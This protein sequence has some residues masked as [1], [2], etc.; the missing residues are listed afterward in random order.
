M[1][2]PL[3]TLL[4]L[5]YV[6]CFAMLVMVIS[7]GKLSLTDKISLQVFTLDDFGSNRGQTAPTTDLA[8]LD[9]LEEEI[10]QTTPPTPLPQTAPSTPDTLALT[11]E[12]QTELSETLREARQPIDYPDASASAL[13]HF[14]DA[15][16][17]LSQRPSSVRIVHYGDSQ[18]EGD[19]ISGYL[20]E[21]LQ[22][23]FG[24]CGVGMVPLWTRD[25]LRST[26]KT[27]PSDTWKKFAYVDA[28]HKPSTHQLGMLAAYYK[29]TPDRDSA[30][31]SKARYGSVV[32]TG[33]SE[34]DKNPPAHHQTERLRLLFRNPHGELQAEIALNNKIIATQTQ[35]IGKGLQ[36]I[37]HRLPE[38]SPYRNIKLRLA[39]S[40]SP[41]L[42]GF[43]MDCQTGISLDN[44][45]I[46]GSSGV[47]FTKIDKER[48]R[49]QF[50]A[51]DVRLLILEFGVNVVPGQAESYA[52]YE[53]LYYKQLKFF[54]SLYPELD[55]LVVSLSDMSR[56]RKGRWESYPN[57]EPIRNAQ[58]RAAFRAGCAFWD[59]YQAMGGRNAMTAW[60]SADPPLASPDYI[61]FSPRGARLAAEMLYNALLNSYQDYKE[62]RLQQSR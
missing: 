50:Q 56:Q 47:E 52:Y 14:F 48:L 59:L 23:R 11:P 33:A 10:D 26:L 43:S 51:M 30:F 57:I 55:I 32:F 38:R 27:D 8:F 17:A 62:K 18:I 1:I 20:R 60:V 2:P 6:A 9:Q 58:K 22:R 21:R 25:N 5:F 3:R 49:E 12:A 37:E 7:P 40:G 29:F 54:K 13:N 19:R 53:N 36:V 31:V 24:G 28:K 44:V 46:R 41:E 39:S 35:P 42:Y 45:P 16:Y 61:H 15:L 4:L 34:K